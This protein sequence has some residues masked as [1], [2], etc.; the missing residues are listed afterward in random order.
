V[1][2]DFRS[3]V[4]RGNSQPPASLTWFFVFPGVHDWVVKSGKRSLPNLL[5]IRSHSRIYCGKRLCSSHSPLQL[6]V[7]SHC[8]LFWLSD[9]ETGTG[10]HLPLADVIDSLFW[11]SDSESE[12]SAQSGDCYVWYC[13]RLRISPASG[14]RRSARFFTLF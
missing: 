14:I 9:V 13:G 12:R 1:L 2:D 8:Q 7:S 5:S 6:R 4:L 11:S 3:I 10:R